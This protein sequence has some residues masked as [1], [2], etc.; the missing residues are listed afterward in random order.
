MSTKLRTVEVYYGLCAGGTHSG[1]WKAIPVQVPTKLDV[2]EARRLAIKLA[3]E[4][5]DTTVRPV[6]FGIYRFDDTHEQEAEVT[7]LWTDN[8]GEA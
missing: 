7:R 4:K 8:G 6:F 3:L 1:I 5:L 2:E